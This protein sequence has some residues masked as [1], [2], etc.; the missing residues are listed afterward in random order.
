[1]KFKRRLFDNPNNL[2]ASK[3]NVTVETASIDTNLPDRDSRLRSADYLNTGRFPLASFV[4]KAIKTTKHNEFD[5]AGNLTLKV[6]P[7]ILS[8]A[9][10]P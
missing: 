1:M 3:V 5:I 9:L 6:L 4:S 2:A 8:S 10:K 7:E